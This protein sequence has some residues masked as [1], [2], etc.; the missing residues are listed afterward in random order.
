[1]I[2]YSMFGVSFAVLCWYRALNHSLPRAIMTASFHLLPFPTSWTFLLTL[3]MTDYY[4][5]SSHSQPSSSPSSQSN[6][7][8]P[9]CLA[10]RL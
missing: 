9:A 7:A 1:M 10:R 4:P 8:Y 3:L 2:L 5:N 6:A